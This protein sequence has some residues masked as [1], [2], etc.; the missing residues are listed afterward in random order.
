MVCLPG[1]PS[2]IGARRCGC[3]IVVV[4]LKATRKRAASAAKD[5]AEGSDSE[6]AGPQS[7]CCC[8]TSFAG[9]R[10]EAKSE[11]RQRSFVRSNPKLGRGLRHLVLRQV[12]DAVGS[13]ELQPS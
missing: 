13:R 6:T 11:I 10:T 9:P 12:G 1:K 2:R 8:I 4:G 7:A 5:R 3:E